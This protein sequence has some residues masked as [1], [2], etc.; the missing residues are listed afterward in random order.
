[1]SKIDVE[2]TDDT[3]KILGVAL[4]STSTNS[5]L[6][7][8]GKSIRRRRKFFIVTPNPE[9]LVLAQT[10]EEF[11]RI[12]NSADLAIP[13]GFGVILA[14]RFLG[15]RPVLNRRLTGAGLT[16]ALLEKSRLEGWRVGVIGA[17]RGVI[18]EQKLTLERLKV[19]YPGLKIECLELVKGWQ[20][21]PPAGGWE[22]ILA[23]QGMG[24]QEKW[25]WENL[26]TTK[27]WVFIGIGSSLDFLTGFSRRAPL[28]WQNWGLEW[29]WRWLQHPRHH[30]RRVIN[31]VIVFNWLVLKEKLR[32]LWA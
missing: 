26:A 4:D 28:G 27:A 6:A 7:E 18:S 29:L 32:R 24:K 11:K 22:V 19:R 20:K 1:M 15:T 23:A 2:K 14:S 17:R 30:F 21:D 9:F 31:A 8:A 5:V 10:D 16:A 12:L 13:D 25:L 3:L